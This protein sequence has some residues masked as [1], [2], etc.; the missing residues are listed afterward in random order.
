MTTATT[1]R[2]RLSL[3]LCGLSGTSCAVL[4]AVVLLLYGTP[5]NSVWWG[6]MAAILLAAFILP[7]AL[8]PAI[9]W[10]IDGYRNQRGG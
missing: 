6:I 2:R 3:V 7:L 4:M 10:V 9:E 1:G 5:Y 8:V